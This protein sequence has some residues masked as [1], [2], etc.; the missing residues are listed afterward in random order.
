EYADAANP[1]RVT[2]VI[3]PR[4][5]TGGTPDYTYATSFAYFTA[6]GSPTQAGLLQS[7]TDPLSDLTTYT[8][9]PVGRRL[10]MVDPNGNVSG[11]SC[12]GAHTWSYTYDAEDRPS[13]T[14]APAPQTAGSAPVT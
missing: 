12:A 8:Y 6:A 1:G 9:D 3:P 5:N 11:C 13:T 14:S 2:R 7:T 10:A 4:G